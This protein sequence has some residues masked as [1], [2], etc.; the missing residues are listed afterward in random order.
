M[1]IFR[2]LFRPT[3]TRDRASSSSTNTS[4]IAIYPSGRRRRIR[5]SLRKRPT[6]LSPEEG[7]TDCYGVDCHRLMHGKGVTASKRG[8]VI[9]R[10]QQELLGSIERQDCRK[11]TKISG[12][13]LKISPRTTAPPSPLVTEEGSASVH[14]GSKQTSE[15][16]MPLRLMA[17][18]ADLSEYHHRE[19]DALL[20]DKLE[21][22]DEAGST[23]SSLSTAAESS[24]MSS[25]STEQQSPEVIHTFIEE[26]SYP[27]ECTTYAD[28]ATN[29]IAVLR[30]RS[31][32]PSS[33]KREEFGTCLPGKKNKS[34]GSLPSLRAERAA[35]ALQY[36]PRKQLGGLA[37]GMPLSRAMTTATPTA[38]TITVTAPTRDLH[39]N[40]TNKNS[41]NQKGFDDQYLHPKRSLSQQ[42]PEATINTTA[43]NSKLVDASW[44][45]YSSSSNNTLLTEMG[46]EDAVAKLVMLLSSSGGA[47]GGGRGLPVV[48]SS[49]N[50]AGLVGGHNKGRKLL[51]FNHEEGLLELCG[52]LQPYFKKKKIP[53]YDIDRVESKWC[54][55]V[56]HAKGRHPVRECS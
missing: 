52:P 16:T 20:H 30:Q 44:N 54:C 36:W 56:I 11:E 12:F 55:L 46:D 13:A 23:T 27:P 10:H 14:E 40:S 9:R 2:R 37:R 6:A 29:T 15:V 28:N 47:G 49:A 33:S 32:V 45:Q 53:V 4:V 7:S 39:I 43:N 26:G 17:R 38:A 41:N 50:T 22:K 31:V 42:G 51:K 35:P 5:R 34:P 19:V 24:P 25:Y 8:A 3:P 1:Y 18:P 21:V 48:K